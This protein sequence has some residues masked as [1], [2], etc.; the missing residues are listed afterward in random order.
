MSG[1]SAARLGT[2]AAAA[3]DW[4]APPMP[5]TRIAPLRSA[6]HPKSAVLMIF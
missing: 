6:I 4:C 1:K 5:L 3:L 2:Q